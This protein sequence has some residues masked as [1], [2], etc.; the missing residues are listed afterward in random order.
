MNLHTVL[1]SGY[2]SLHSHQQCKR[3]LFSPQPLQRLLFVDFLMMAI[4]MGVRWYFTV[5][6]ICISLVITT[7]TPT[8][9]QKTGNTA[10]PINRKLVLIFTEHRPRP[11]GARSRFPHSQSLPSGSFHK[12]F[13]LIH[14]RAYRM[15]TRKTEN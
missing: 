15:K 9:Q 8:H 3:V 4:L 1:H 13:I 10:P 12:P 6:L 5:V 14:Q 2:I 7:T 11:S